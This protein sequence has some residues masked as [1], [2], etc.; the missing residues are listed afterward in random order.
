MKT[1]NISI[2]G[3]Q[4]TGASI[5]LALQEGP[6][7]FTLVGHDNDTDLIKKSLEAGIIDTG[8]TNLIR[9]VA[10]ADIVVLA[11]PAVELEGTLRAIG[12]ELQDH[13]LVIDL[14][15][16]KAQ[17]MKF[18]EQYLKNGYYVGARPIFSAATFSERISGSEQARADLFRQSVFCVMPGAQTDPQAVETAV[19]FGRLLGATPY[20]VDPL[21]YDSLAQGVE[22][23]PG[24]FAAAI[25]AAVNKTTGWRDILRFADLPFATAT[26]PLESGADELACLALND[27]LA[28][29]RWLDALVNEINVMR[30]L[31]HDGNL[32]LLTAVLDEM[33]INRAEWLHERR[34]NDWSEI[35]ETNVDVPG[36]GQRFLGGLANLGGNR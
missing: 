25:F 17:G 29:L 31:I 2:I 8:E 34:Q 6:L 23:M 28:T 35:K 14:T 20:F 13:A 12:A 19:N 18:A 26:M 24:L 4:R 7:D 5:A 16:L 21:E 27:K 36:V 9:A 22:A 15:A 11:I 32:E 1:K 33:E 10:A 30:R 3:L